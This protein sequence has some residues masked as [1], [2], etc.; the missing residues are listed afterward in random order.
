MQGMG[1]G[2]WADEGLLTGENSGGRYAGTYLS[3][4]MGGGITL[5]VYTYIIES[6][7]WP[8]NRTGMK[9]LESESSAPAPA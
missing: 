8:P 7:H 1:N 3:G 4:V 5:V 2:G 6:I 9:E